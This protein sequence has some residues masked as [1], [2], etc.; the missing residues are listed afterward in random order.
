[1]SKDIVDLIK[2]QGNQAC[3]MIPDIMD[4]P[5]IDLGETTIKDGINELSADKKQQLIDFIYKHKNS[6]K[7]WL[8]FNEDGLEQKILM[9]RTEYTTE[10]G[11]IY[12]Y[13]SSPINFV[14][15]EG[16]TVDIGIYII[17]V[18]KYGEDEAQLVFGLKQLK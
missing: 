13:A 6:H 7:F 14:L 5:A 9:T 16:T 12:A 17:T 18:F 11:E 8:E 1:M 10:F 4:I 15:S 3:V 2:A